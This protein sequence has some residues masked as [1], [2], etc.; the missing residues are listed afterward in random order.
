MKLTKKHINSIIQL[1][2]KLRAGE[3]AANMQEMMWDQKVA[4]FAQAGS[5]TC[6]GHR[7][8][9]LHAKGYGENIANSWHGRWVSPNPGD[10]YYSV[11]LIFVYVTLLVNCQPLGMFCMYAH[12]SARLVVSR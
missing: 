11:C 3:R 5:D 4:A 1:H 12:I 8:H 2:N 7:I 9:A 10:M 6:G